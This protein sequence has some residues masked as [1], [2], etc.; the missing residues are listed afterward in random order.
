[1]KEH[2]GMRPQD[3]VILL[4][5]AIE[6]EDG[7][8]IKDLSSKLFISASKL[9]NLLTVLLLPGYFYMIAGL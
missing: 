3:V 9:V 2:K 6:S 1:M 8:R 7:T 5:L 4:K